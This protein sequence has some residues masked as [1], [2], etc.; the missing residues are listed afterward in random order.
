M[1]C[2]LDCRHVGPFINSVAAWAHLQSGIQIAS[3]AYRMYSPS[4]PRA[5]LRKEFGDIFVL[6]LLSL[7]WREI[8]IIGVK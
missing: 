8:G 6:L 4:N 7:H 3:I 5:T 1:R 2:R